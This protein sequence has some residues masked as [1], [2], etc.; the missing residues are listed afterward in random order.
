MRASAIQLILFAVLVVACFPQQVVELPSQSPPLQFTQTSAMV[1]QATPGAQSDALDSG[2]LDK[3]AGFTLYRLDAVLDYSAHFLTVS[4]FIDYFNNSHD[5]LTELVLVSASQYDNSTL[6]FTQLTWSDGAEITNTVVDQAGLHIR[7]DTPLN[8]GQRVQV[9]LEY[10]LA[11]P[12]GPGA[13][14]WT[15]RQTNLIDWYP[16]IPQYV[17]GEGWLINPPA[18]VGEHFAY[19]SADFEVTI[20]LVNEPSLTTIAAPANGAHDEAGWHF[21]LSNARRFVWSVSNQYETLTANQNDTSISVFFFDEHRDAAEASLTIAKQAL[22][23]YEEFYGPYPYENLSIVEALFADGM[24]SDGIFFL[25]QYYFLTYD[26]SPRNYLT[27]L[28]VHEIAHNWWFGQVGNDQANEPWLDEAFA[29]YSELVFYE[30]IYPSHVDWWWQFRVNDHAPNGPVDLTIY[31]TANFREY[32]NAV[33]LRGVQFLHDVRGV[34]GDETFFAFIRQHI[35]DGAGRIVSAE[36]FL[37]R[38]AYATDVVPLRPIMD[39]YFRLQ[40]Q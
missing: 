32:V 17:S 23:T 18:A 14:A 35:S 10:T 19:E 6:T 36:E 37:W 25:D 24:E 22:E 30:N 31:E 3:A 16:F 26:Y 8:P 4:E 7:L 2:R 34:M 33:Y 15:E 39:E 21:T 9:N 13:L 40:D 20:D 38:L 28:T 29:T 11:L 5:S 27:I 1:E 12:I